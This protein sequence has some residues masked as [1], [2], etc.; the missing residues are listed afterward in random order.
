[1]I[2]IISWQSMINNLFQNYNKVINKVLVLLRI[3][4]YFIFKEVQST[5][6]YTWIFVTKS[7]LHFICNAINSLNFVEFYQDHNS[8]LTNHFVTVVE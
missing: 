7:F 3:L 5:S 2:V 1:M 4:F 6:H 8:L